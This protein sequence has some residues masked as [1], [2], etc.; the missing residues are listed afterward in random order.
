MSIGPVRTRKR[1]R[2]TVAPA[3]LATVALAGAAIFADGSASAAP[4]PGGQWFDNS[5][6]ATLTVAD[7]G[8]GFVDGYGREVVLRGFNVSGEA[9]LAED[10]GLPFASTADAQASAAAMRRLTGADTIRFLITWASIEPQPNTIDYTYLAH[11]TAQLRAFLDQGFHVLVDF[12]QDLYSRY[13]FNSGS[14][15]TGD[16]APQWVVAAGH[17]PA[18]SC[19]ICINWGQNITQNTA[20]QDAT[21]DFWH[22]RVLSTSAGQIAVQDAYLAQA[23]AVLSYFT[24]QLSADEFTHMLGV[25]PFNEPYAGKYDSGQTS[26]TWERDVLWPFFQKF[27]ATMDAAGWQAKPA[28]VEPNLFWNSDIFFENQAG[29]LSNVGAIGTRY[30]FNTHFYDDAAISGIFMPGKAGDGQYSSEFATVRDRAATLGTGAFVSEFGS[31]ESGYTS[32]KTPTVLK[33]MYQALDSRVPGG[34]WWSQAPSSGPVLG[35]TEW[36][37]DVYSGR[38]DESMNGNPSKVETSGD[39][40]NGEDFSVVDTGVAGVTDSDV[41][42][43]QDAR[44]L[45]RLYPIAV[46][47]HTVAFTYEDRSRDGSDTLTWNPIPANMPNTAALAGSGQYGV[48]VWRSNGGAAPTEIHLPASFTPAATSVISDLGTVAS[49]PAYSATG[50]VAA[51]LIAYAPLPGGGGAERLLLTDTGAAGTLHYALVTNGAGAVTSAR[52]AAAKQE[53]DSWISSLSFK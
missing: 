29:G 52:L 15:Y 13:I 11:V 8:S 10:G 14:W 2:R 34:S 28:F 46:A 43:R 47:G 1:L 51:S 3:L 26:L 6:S 48:L 16:G 24:R 37:W 17:Y 35:G 12:H 38:H 30:V 53:M 40:W 20:V 41:Q 33:A 21:Y 36:Q 39:A 22:N 19:G 45:D 7:G 49:L 32:D 50:Q 9:K 4:P 18:E 27:R 25:D 44:V 5:T 31:P 23:Q 42:L